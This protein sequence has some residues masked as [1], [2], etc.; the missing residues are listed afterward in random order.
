MCKEPVTFLKL[1]NFDREL[2]FFADFAYH[3]S[4]HSSFQHSQFDYH[5]DHYIPPRPNQPPPYEPYLPPRP[6]NYGGSHGTNYLPPKPEGDKNWGQY[7]GTYGSGSYAHH[8][9]DHWGLKKFHNYGDI[10]PSGGNYLPGLPDKPP[11]DKYLPPD[12]PLGGTYLPSHGLKPSIS[13]GGGSYLP[14]HGTGRPIG[15]EGGAYLPSHDLGRPIG[16]VGGSYLPSRVPQQPIGPV[17]GV[18]LPSHD[19]RPPFEV[20]YRP[21][22]DFPNSLLP[23]EPRQPHY[24]F[25]K[26]GKS[27]KN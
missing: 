10:P 18:Y 4:H 1:K 17:G 27:F 6:P 5:G 24:N 7:G 25:L 8:S 13:E 15:T 11:A 26:D 22:D 3:Q 14:S 9:S 12:K 23:A 16:S 2:C 21:H 19:S 20:G